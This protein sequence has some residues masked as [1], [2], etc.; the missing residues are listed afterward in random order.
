MNFVLDEFYN[1][2]MA[3]ILEHGL[4]ASQI[5]NLDETGIDRAGAKSKVAVAA[6]AKDAPGVIQVTK[7]HISIVTAVC[8]NGDKMPPLF[9]FKGIE[10]SKST[11]TP[12]SGC[13]ED[14]MWT[15]TG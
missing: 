4:K 8:A 12:L 6:D 7:E 9:I 2:L 13:P 14:W 3:L 1:D 11:V 10:G 15:K 5:W